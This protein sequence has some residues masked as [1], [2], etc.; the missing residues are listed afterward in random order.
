MSGPRLLVT[1]SRDWTDWAKIRSALGEALRDL[2]G[3]PL[4]VGVSSSM[5]EQ[6]PPGVDALARVRLVHGNARGADRM[7]SHVWRRWYL[8]VEAHPAD[9]G[10]YGRNAGH[11][12][13]AQMVRAGADLC[14]AFIL[15]CQKPDCPN[16]EPHG[17]HGASRC[18]DLAQLAGIETRVIPAD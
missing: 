12:R 2:G 13:N 18:A 4:T 9:W 5:P 6:P 3:R 17:T 16:P 10:R 1:G 15:P 11:I 7:C 8:P 14:L